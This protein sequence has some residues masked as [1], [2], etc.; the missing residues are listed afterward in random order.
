MKERPVIVGMGPAGMFAGLML[1]KHGYR[2]IIIER[3]EAIEERSK[4]IE[5]FWNTGALNIESNVQFGEGERV[6]FLM[7][8]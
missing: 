6:L 8:S 7:E 1:A 4:T 2:P 3:G 5:K